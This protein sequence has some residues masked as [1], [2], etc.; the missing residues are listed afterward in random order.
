MYIYKIAPNTELSI[1]GQPVDI[2]EHTKFLCNS[3]SQDHMKNHF[4]CMS[5]KMV[6]DIDIIERP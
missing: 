6:K 4:D 2:I 5:S 3:W 1:Y